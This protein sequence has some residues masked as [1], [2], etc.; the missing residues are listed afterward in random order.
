MKILNVLQEDLDT[1]DR[2]ISDAEAAYEKM[3]HP[4]PYIG[5]FHLEACYVHHFFYCGIHRK[6]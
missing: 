1:I 4:D 5:K 2:L 6:Y 3:R